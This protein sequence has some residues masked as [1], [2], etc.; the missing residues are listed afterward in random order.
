MRRHSRL[1]GTEDGLVGYW[2]MDGGNMQDNSAY[3]ANGTLYGGA[4]IVPSTVSETPSWLSFS[5]T[6]G[7]IVQGTPQDIQLNI[8]T[9]DMIGGSY[10]ANLQVRSNDPINSIV[11]IPIAMQLAGYALI[12]ISHEELDFGN[13]FAGEQG[14]RL[15]TIFNNGSDVLDILGFSTTEHRSRYRYYSLLIRPVLIART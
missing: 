13:V 4:Q 6:F 2:S 5:D 11:Q 15:L 10:N 7:A 14:T 1:S 3:M 12:S 8:N 9:T